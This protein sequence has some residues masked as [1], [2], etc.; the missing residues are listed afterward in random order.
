MNSI[1]ESINTLD[2][3]VTGNYT[4]TNQKINTLTGSVDDLRT[5]IA[6]PF[7]FKGT[8]A[9]VSSLP[10][11]GNTMNDTYFVEDQ[12]CLYSWNGTAWSQSSY[13]AD[14]YAQDLADLKSA[15]SKT[16]DGLIPLSC[17]P[18]N[19]GNLFSTGVWTGV[20]GTT[21]K[22]VV[23]P[24]KPGDSV[25]IGAENAVVCGF[26]RSYTKPTA[27]GDTP[28]YST[29]TGYTT[30]IGLAAGMAR[31]FIV[32][33]DTTV[34]VIGTM[35]SNSDT[36]PHT[37]E[38]NGFDLCKNLKAWIDEINAKADNSV[39]LA[40]QAADE[41]GEKINA[42]Y[43]Y[44]IQ[45]PTEVKAGYLWNG[46]SYIPNQSTHTDKYDVSPGDII[47]VYGSQP[48][49]NYLL[50]RIYDS[51][52]TELTNSSE[53]GVVIGGAVSTITVPDNASYLIT[54]A[55][56]A[57]VSR[58][59]VNTLENDIN[60]YI[61]KSLTCEKSN[62]GIVVTT[63]SG[64]K[65]DVCKIGN[66]NLMNLYRG[67]FNDIQLFATTTDWIGP[68]NFTK[69]SDYHGDQ[70]SGTT[71]GNHPITDGTTSAATAE[72]VEWKVVCDGSVVDNGS[73]NCTDCVLIWTNRVMAGNTAKLDG[74]GEYCLTE[75]VRM[76]FKADGSI[77]V[78]LKF[79]P[80]FDCTMHWY[81]G[82]QFAGRNFAEN[83]YIP[84]YSTEFIAT[85]DIMSIATD[86]VVSRYLVEGD[87]YGVEM[88]LDRSFGFPTN[89]VDKS[90]TGNSTKAYFTQVNY[91]ST[92]VPILADHTYMW[93]GGYKF[94]VV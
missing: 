64:F 17:Y 8:V 1:V 50:Y 61:T 9:T 10:S 73:H 84:E 20:T 12:N 63:A 66:N 83:V 5:Q 34:L 68:Y 90:V 14:G 80:L 38:I 35:W 18:I 76:R 29:A 39:Q 65:F 6:S 32:P 3:T 67:Y 94:Y 37:V 25:V 22:H 77:D 55:Y 49:P 69:D 57:E 51:A 82:L 60:Y 23:V 33:S 54:N 7:T 26:L 62:D 92:P 45:T 88:W 47:T 53:L 4:E 56:N 27:N 40:I 48:A 93:R 24:V 58:I 36:T 78:D 41:A 59:T 81:S 30:R 75:T 44:D 79:T 86:A 85:S 13:D 71:G 43:S 16:L 19:P 31:D 72:T 2:S 15:F 46:E 28:N 70:A 89:S 11:S 52:G 91:T 21:F 42:E 87:E 74:S